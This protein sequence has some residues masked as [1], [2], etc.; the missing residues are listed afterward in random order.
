MSS[1]SCA[2]ELH[3]LIEQDDSKEITNALIGRG[4]SPSSPAMT[5]ISAALKD[6][7]ALS[8]EQRQTLTRYLQTLCP[9]PSPSPRF[10]TRAVAISRE[11]AL[12]EAADESLDANDEFFALPIL[13]LRTNKALARLFDKFEP[14]KRLFRAKGINTDK[15]ADAYSDASDSS[16]R[17]D[18]VR[19]SSFSSLILL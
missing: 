15:I 10:L 6:G 3:L 19:L 17:K 5:A 18:C 9:L 14:L 16:G 11:S 7:K 1:A 2:A 8:P 13:Q 4:V 12:F